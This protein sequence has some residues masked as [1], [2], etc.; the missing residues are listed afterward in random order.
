MGDSDDMYLMNVLMTALKVVTGR[1]ETHNK[2]YD[3]IF[4]ALKKGEIAI[5]CGVNIGHYT[6]VMARKGATV[7][8][9]KPNPHAFKVLKEKFWFLD[10]SNG[11]E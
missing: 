6:E 10:E 4:H 3:R 1:T 7:H 8:A 2:K 11:I 5:D 9:F